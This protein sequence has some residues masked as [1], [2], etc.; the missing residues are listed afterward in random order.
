MIFRALFDHVGDLEEDICHKEVQ[1]KMLCTT[2]EA[3]YPPIPLKT[4]KALR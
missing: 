2:V 1:F 3:S 4:I